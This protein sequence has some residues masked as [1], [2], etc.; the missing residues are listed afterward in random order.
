M[1][2][3]RAKALTNQDMLSHLSRVGKAAQLLK[4]NRTC[5]F[6]DQTNN[7]AA[8]MD[9][10]IAVPIDDPNADTEWYF[11]FYSEILAKSKLSQE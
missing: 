3:E 10:R 5:D 2:K 9:E 7:M 4:G 11:V 8:P 1:W 6:Q